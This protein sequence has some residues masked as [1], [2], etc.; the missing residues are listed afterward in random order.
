MYVPPNQLFCNGEGINGHVT[1][2]WRCRRFSQS[3]EVT[4]TQRASGGTNGGSGCLVLCLSK[5]SPRAA[6]AGVNMFRCPSKR[7]CT[8]KSFACYLMII[9]MNVICRSHAIGATSSGRHQQGP[10]GNSPASLVGV[11][12]APLCHMVAMC[13]PSNLASHSY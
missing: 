1:R 6:H 4:S 7:I 8:A 13:K 11:V 5:Q 12:A 9:T 3:Y 10:P 2:T